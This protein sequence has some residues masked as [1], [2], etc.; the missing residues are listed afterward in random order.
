[1]DLEF[2]W[3]ISNKNFDELENLSYKMD[4]LNELVYQLHCG[5]CQL[6]EDNN[7]DCEKHPLVYALSDTISD[8]CKIRCD[9]LTNIINEVI[10]FTR[11]LGG[12]KEFIKLLNYCKTI[13]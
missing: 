12:Q 8:T 13:V 1:M 6:M 9:D 7:L 10:H 5:I 3:L 2:T 11:I 4:R